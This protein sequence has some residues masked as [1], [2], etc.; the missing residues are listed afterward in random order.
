MGNHNPFNRNVST[1]SNRHNSRPHLLVRICNHHGNRYCEALKKI[2]VAVDDDARGYAKSRSYRIFVHVMK[3]I[4][5]TL[6]QNVGNE[7]GYNQKNLLLGNQLHTLDDS[8]SSLLVV[9]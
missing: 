2:F 5:E 1:F 4:F 6:N 9:K 3:V 7:I 8:V